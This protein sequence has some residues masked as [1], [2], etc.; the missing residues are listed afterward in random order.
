MVFVVIYEYI[1]CTFYVCTM[2]ILRD[3]LCLVV[4]HINVD[5]TIYRLLSVRFNLKPY[6]SLFERLT[7]ARHEAPR[8]CLRRFNIISPSTRYDGL[9]RL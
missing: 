3:S 8:E 6:H 9:I 2:Y 7:R 4:H 1:C 5:K